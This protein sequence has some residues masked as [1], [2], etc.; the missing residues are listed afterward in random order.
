MPKNSDPRV[1][2]SQNI[3]SEHLYRHTWIMISSSSI[4]GRR[5]A[6]FLQNYH[7]LYF[8]LWDFFIELILKHVNIASFLGFLPF[9]CP[10]MMLAC[11]YMFSLDRKQKHKQRRKSNVYKEFSSK[12]CSCS[13]NDLLCMSSLSDD[14]NYFCIFSLSSSLSLQSLSQLQYLFNIVLLCTSPRSSLLAAACAVSIAWLSM[15]LLASLHASFL[16]AEPILVDFDR[17]ESFGEA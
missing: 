12:N 3:W 14:P 7:W 10:T 11:T 8:V 9:P 1:C 6:F 17:N 5:R 13:N 4:F 2:R 15:M 16:V